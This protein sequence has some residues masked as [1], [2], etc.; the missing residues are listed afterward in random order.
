MLGTRTHKR[1]DRGRRR[2]MG[3]INRGGGNGGEPVR[4]PPGAARYRTFL[5]PILGRYR[6][7]SGAKYGLEEVHSAGL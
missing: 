4:S 7:S 2:T 5:S 6:A 3:R 1:G